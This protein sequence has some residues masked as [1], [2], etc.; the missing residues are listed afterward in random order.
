MW[1]EYKITVFSIYLARKAL[2][3]HHHKDPLIMN[4]KMG[5]GKKLGNESIRWNRRCWFRG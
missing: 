3:N 5:V 4:I 2:E 1:K